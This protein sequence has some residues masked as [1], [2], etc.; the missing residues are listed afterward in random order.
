MDDDK[1]REVIYSTI[2]DFFQTEIMSGLLGLL[3][4]SE[5]RIDETNKMIKRL[6][7]ICAKY[8]ETYSCHLASLESSRDKALEGSGLLAQANNRLTEE[9]SETRTRLEK[10][11]ERNAGLIDNYFKLSQ[12]AIKCSG[13]S[14]AEVKADINVRK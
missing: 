7:D 1:L 12:A 10:E 6:S 3:K 4:S 2:K 9:L 13:K 11:I 14:A 5:E 8:T